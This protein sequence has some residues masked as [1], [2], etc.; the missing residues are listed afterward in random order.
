MPNNKKL[1]L[2]MFKLQQTLNDDT[3][4]VGWEK[5]YNKH[6]R[7][8]NWKRCIYMEAAELIDSFNWKHWK[9]I[10]IAPDWDNITI[11]LVD[12]WHFIMSLGLEEYKNNSLGSIKDIVD[13]VADTKYYDDFCGE[14]ITPNNSD[15]LQIVST[16]EHLIKDAID[17][18]DFTK[19]LDTFF[20]TSLQCGLNI[21]ILYKYY[22]GKN[23]LNKF[24]QDN[25]YKEGTYKKSWNGVEDNV[26]MTDVLEQESLGA[27][28]LY[29]KLEEIY[30]KL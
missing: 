10:N 24:R 4:G 25:G 22:L 9:D 26:V 19:I 8:I 30:K 15:A 20:I 13:Y 6:D 14:A 28:A 11:E 21:D 29:S 1:V 23:I 3:N 18:G 16:I 17:D 7:I 12:I 27:D 2:E 5:G